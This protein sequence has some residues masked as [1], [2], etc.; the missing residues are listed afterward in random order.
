MDTV[1][2][3]SYLSTSLAVAKASMDPTV[4]RTHRH[5]SP[6][7]VLCL[8][9]SGNMAAVNYVGPYYTVLSTDSRATSSSGSLQNY[10]R[11]N[12]VS[13]VFVIGVPP[14]SMRFSLGGLSDPQPEPPFLATVVCALL[15][16]FGGSFTE[17]LC[18][19]TPFRHLS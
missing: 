3:G 17:S 9:F 11:F 16:F 12:S 10:T 2:V 18:T 7:A 19:T 1:S 15:F 5:L 8:P 14:S 6:T 13:L 4:Q